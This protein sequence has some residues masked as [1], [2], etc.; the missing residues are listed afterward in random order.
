MSYY[1]APAP[2]WQYSHGQPPSPP[3][4]LPPSPP[5]T[6]YPVEQPRGGAAVHRPPPAASA[7]STSAAALYDRTARA[8]RGQIHEDMLAFRRAN[9]RS[10]ATTIHPSSAELP[11]RAHY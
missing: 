3:P 6:H 1:R 10:Q 5:R 2:S 7:S 4:S 11:A 8:F 9:V